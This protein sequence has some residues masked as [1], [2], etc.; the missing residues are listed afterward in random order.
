MKKWEF[1]LQREGDTTW[2]PLESPDVEILEGRYRI[3]SRSELANHTL[4]V[5]ITHHALDEIPPVRRVQTRTVTTDTDGLASICSFSRLTPGSWEISCSPQLPA[6]LSELELEPLQPHNVQL[7]VLPNDSEPL[8]SPQF[9]AADIAQIAEQNRPELSQNL[10]SSDLNISTDVQVS[11]ISHEIPVVESPES[12]GSESLSSVNAS[13]NG[14]NIESLLQLAL[15]QNSYIAKLGQ[16]FLI[17][18]QLQPA[19]PKT[20]IESPLDKLAADGLNLQVLLRDPQNSEVLIETQQNL[21]PISSL[22]FPFF[23]VVYIPF[24]CRTRSIWGEIHLMERSQTITT[25][26]FTVSTQVEHLLQ[27]VASEADTSQEVMAEDLAEEVDPVDRILLPLESDAPEPPPLPRIR[28][29]PE[30]GSLSLPSLHPAAQFD[31]PPVPPPTSSSFSEGTAAEP[32]YEE[33]VGAVDSPVV[34]SSIVSEFAPEA[35]VPLSPEQEAF[36]ELQTE[37]RFW[38]RLNAL[39]KDQDLSQWMKRSMPAPL[40]NTPFVQLD[41]QATSLPEA[42]GQQPAS[43]SEMAEQDT[44]AQSMEVGGVRDLEAQEVVVDLDPLAPVI[45]PHSPSVSQG[46]TAPAPARPSVSSQPV[47]V[48][49]DATL[50]VAGGMD[51]PAFS[52]DVMVPA[53][54]LEVMAEQ[55]MAGRSVPVRVRLAEGLPRIYVKIWVYDRQSRQIVDGP[56]WLTEF[57]PNGLDQIETVTDLEIA[58]GSLEVQIEAIAVE[59]QSQRESRKVILERLVTPPPSPKLPLEGR[60]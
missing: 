46:S 31:K 51:S 6:G 28:F 7:Q 5:R 54:I 23:C 3:I 11:P 29:R 52:E 43:L 20:G 34:D 4:D 35:P 22:P 30:T 40:P 17:S 38:G 50:N 14:A 39:A 49:N 26:S 9:T 58:Y 59:M 24:E 41:P 33:S 8:E 16:A 18:G 53:P 13:H 10:R 44:A 19:N 57:S 36:K 1:L 45:K 55:L 21:P 48:R 47:P 27:A 32:A 12:L 42:L 56:R 37:N 15:N 25:C 2:L 60:K